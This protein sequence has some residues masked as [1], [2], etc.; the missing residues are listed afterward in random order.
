MKEYGWRTI[1][2]SLRVIAIKHYE[3][4][5][6]V[7]EEDKRDKLI[8]KYFLVD[9]LCASAIA[10]K[11][12]PALVC[13][14][15]RSKGKQL[16]ACSIIRIIYKHCPYLKPERNE[17]ETDPRVRLMRKR[18]ITPSKHIKQCAFCGNKNSLE[19][20][21]MIPLMFGGDNDERNLIFLCHECHAQVT[22]YQMQLKKS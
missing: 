11:N 15:N 4:M 3:G 22:Q 7:T 17:R 14:S 20:H 12:D 21:H 10:R 9:N 2:I 18:K 8:M 13:Y 5:P 19:E 1:P 16:T 6:E